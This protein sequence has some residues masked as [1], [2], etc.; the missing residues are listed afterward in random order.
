MSNALAIAGVT[1]VLQYYLNNLYSQANVASNFPSS[2][3]VSCLAPDQVQNQIESG[4]PDT[5]NQVNLFLHQVTHNAAWRNVDFA[6]ISADGTQRTGNPPLALDLHYLLTVY[7]SEYWQAEALLGYALMMLHEAP[8]LTRTD[9]ANAIQQITGSPPPFPENPPPP[10]YPANPLT[11]FLNTAGL[12]DQIEMIKITPESM[13]REELA[14]LWTALKADYRP[15]FPFQVSVVL[16]QPDLTSSFA[17]P[18]LQTVFAP[19][20]DPKGQA[21]VPMQTPQILS[22]QVPSGQI[23]AEPGQTVTVTGV[24]LTG[25]S[26]VSLTN[27]RYGVQFTAPVAQSQAESL[28]FVLSPDASG[29]YP[30]GVYDLTVQ[31]MDP[32]NTF[33]Q[34]STNTLQIAIAPGLPAQSATTSS[35]GG[36]ATL[37]TINSFSPVVWEGQDVVLALSTLSAPL[38]SVSAQAQAFVG[39]PN[40]PAVSSLSFLFDDT[41]PTG[42]GLLGRLQVDGVTS[43]V[44]VDTSVFPPFLGPLVTL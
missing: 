33:V 18:V 4:T 41:L 11:G 9:I 15:T 1:A 6:S 23:G 12:A 10:P 13:S 40:S 21:A 30:A 19:A 2:V 32:T 39:P 14:W 27:A 25:A 17:L 24:F 22:I 38:T 5:E 31:F 8:V 43:A 42:V 29:E 7:G 20:V 26:Q 36:T 16:L 44:T 37:V 28:K 35:P 3:T 34:T